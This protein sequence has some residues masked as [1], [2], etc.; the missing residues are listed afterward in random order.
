VLGVRPESIRV[1]LGDTAV[2]PFGLGTY[3]SRTSVIH[4]TALNR[5][6][7]EV[8]ERL[9]AV[10]AHHLEVDAG[11]LEVSGGR[12][13]VRGTSEGVD[14]SYIAM[15]THLHRASLPPGMET[16]ALAA[17][18]SHDAPCE[19]PDSNGYG[20]FA[21]NY[22][23]SATIVVVEV[24]PRTGKVTIID[25][26]SAEDVGR[27]L[28]PRMLEGQIQGGIAQGIGYALGE[29]LMFDS[30]G[31][32]LNASM[33]DYQVPTAPMVPHFDPKK[34]IA[35]ESHDPTYPLGNKG[36]GESGMTPAAAAVACAIFDAIGAPVMSLP[37]TPEKVLAAAAR[38]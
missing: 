10:A 26:A 18:A 15:L 27:V 19:V 16:T 8:K 2:A 25:W 33:V 9:L 20:N 7:L 21:A 22:T 14:V 6:C 35:L 13:T 12:I 24:D 29:E 23:C 37:L 5:A 30:S 32:M 28:H 34:L 1:I 11:D 17:T 36:V 38:S 31:I 4:A 3:A